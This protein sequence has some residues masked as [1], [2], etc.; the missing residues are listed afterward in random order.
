LGL[1]CLP[2][3]DWL[4]ITLANRILPSVAEIDKLSSWRNFLVPVCGLIDALVPIWFVV[5]ILPMLITFRLIFLCLTIPLLSFVS[6]FPISEGSVLRIAGSVALGL[7]VFSWCVVI[8][9]LFHVKLV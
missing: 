5:V 1:I 7:G 4:L 3:A 8:F 2:L 9:G 6:C